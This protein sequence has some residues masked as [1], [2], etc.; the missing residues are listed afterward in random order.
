MRRTS[1]IL[2]L[3]FAPVERWAS[4]WQML[5]ALFII[6]VP[7]AYVQMFTMGPF[8]LRDA[9]EVSLIV[10]FVAVVSA[11]Y[12]LQK[13]LDTATD[14]APKLI[15]TGVSKHENVP[16]HDG[17]GHVFGSPTFYHV[18]LANKPVGT[19]NRPTARKVAG[20][21]QIFDI[22]GKAIGEDRLHRWKHSPG[23]LE[24]G[25]H[26]DVMLA[27]DILPNGVEWYFDIAMKYEADDNFYTPN[28]DTAITHSDC[29]DPAIAFGPGTY[30]ARMEFL[31]ENLS[32]V[33]KCRIQNE[34][35]GKP[36]IIEVV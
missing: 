1:K 7:P 26:A 9:L 6:V 12:R 4:W 29:R 32:A 14:E 34:G 35:A 8:K 5:I 15:V 16:I 28:N 27:E 30:I 13:T 36:L 23:P 11:A 18:K 33:V 22:N 3:T 31:G 20:R 17:R 24:V 21:V 25:K 10:V 2:R 19:L